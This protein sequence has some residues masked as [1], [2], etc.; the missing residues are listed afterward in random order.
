MTDSVFDVALEKRFTDSGEIALIDV[1]SNDML[2]IRNNETGVVMRIAFSTLS[3]AVMTAL[4]GSD[5][6]SKLGYTPE[7]SA[8][9]GN[10]NGYAGLDSN[11][12]VPISQLPSYVDDVLE[13]ANVGAFP[14]TG[15]NGKI[16]VAIDTNFTYRW[17]GSA[18]VEISQSLA[19]GETS[20]TA[21]RGDRGKTAYEHSQ[22]TSGNPHNVTKS[23]V[24][25]ANAENKT[26]ANGVAD[27]THS[28]TS[29]TTPIDDDELPLLDSAAGNI[30]KKITWSNIKAT[31]KTY[32]DTL[33]PS[34]TEGTFN[35]TVEGTTTTGTVT[36]NSRYGR[37]TKIGRLVFFEIYLYWQD[38]TGSG[39]LRIGNLPFNAGNGNVYT[40]VTVGSFWSYTF[41]ANTFLLA[42]IKDNNS[43]SIDVYINP[44]GG[45]DVS[46]TPA[47]YDSV[48]AIT[49]SG[50]YSV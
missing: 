44:I 11:G 30:L 8:N 29:K 34:K 25:L 37:Y 16:Y 5:I 36:Y 41:N 33:Y 17:S 48:A 50:F 47:N 9:K 21:Y 18:Y 15:E 6:I 26:F 19:L 42:N 1:T 22:L 40:A 32:F 31:L 10:A 2:L 49:L 35:P 4:S 12:K 13:Y 23:D 24:G 20:S 46:S 38:G 43:N 27:S 28:A 14:A 3:S 7:N 39:G 45:T